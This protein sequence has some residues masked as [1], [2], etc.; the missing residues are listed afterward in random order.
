MAYNSL[1]N[2]GASITLGVPK[3]KCNMRVAIGN[4]VFFVWV[5]DANAKSCC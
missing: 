1:P 2:F 5:V 4:M 3:T